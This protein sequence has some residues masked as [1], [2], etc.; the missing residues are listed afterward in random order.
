[1]THRHKLEP[2]RKK[3]EQLPRAPFFL[4]KSF[5]DTTINVAA[6]Q[7]EIDGVRK[8]VETVLVPYETHAKPRTLIGVPAANTP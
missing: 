3:I 6:I 8:T 7:A 4:M 2:L 5:S 1:M